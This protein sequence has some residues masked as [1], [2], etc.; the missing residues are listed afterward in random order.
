MSQTI[1]FKVTPSQHETLMLRTTENGF[2]DLTSYIKVVALNSQAFNPAPMERTQEEACVE[3]AFEVSDA[4]KERIEA[5][6]KASNYENISEYLT[7]TT[8]HAVI[9]AIIE[10]RSTGTLDAMLARIAASKKG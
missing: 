2:D 3:I 6:M 7:Y 8:L 9:S 5:N 1:T 10:V 4:Q